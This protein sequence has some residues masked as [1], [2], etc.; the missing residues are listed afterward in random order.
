[1]KVFVCSTRYDLVLE[2]E[3]VLRVIHALGLE[4]GSMES[5]FG[6]RSCRS[7]STCLAEVRSSDLVVVVVGHRYGNVVP[8]LGVSFSHAEYLEA[9]NLGKPCLV[10]F[11]DPDV[12]IHRTHVETDPQKRELLEEWKAVLQDNHTTWRFNNEHGLAAQVVK[13]LTREV[14]GINRRQRQSREPDSHTTRLRYAIGQ[15]E[16][17]VALLLGTGDESFDWRTMRFEYSHEWVP[18]HPLI[19]SHREQWI[20]EEAV[21]ARERDITLF[22]GPCVRLHSFG[23]GVNQ[24]GDGT[25]RKTPVLSLRP[26]CWFDYVAS[27]RWLDREFAGPDGKVITL[28]PELADE[29]AILDLQPS[30]IQLSNILTVS[31]VLLTEDGWTVVGRRTGLVDNTRGV[32]QASAAEN[33]HRWKDEPSDSSNPWSLPH[34]LA[35]PGARNPRVDYD[36]APKAPPN[37][38]FTALRGLRE[39]VGREVG[40]QSTFEQVRCL[41]LAWDWLNFNPHLYMFVRISLSSI[42]VQRSIDAGRAEDRFEV[43]PE[44]MR[45]EPRGQLR[46]LLV[47]GEVADV[48][49]GVLLR[50]LVHAFGYPEVTRS[51]T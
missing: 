35:A 7:I 14:A 36:Y 10:Y 37:P 24:A 12:P 41:G 5:S 21:D 49:K 31:V 8:E 25:E 1:M 2:R 33:V 50:A 15:V 29:R 28:R 32:Y 40:N 42:E 16:A 30:R 27:N 45:F 46:D 19:D 43:T 4:P 3:A 13:D 9:L 20:A 11:K 6:A 17:K 47:D 18:L 22:N 44:L 39:E 34:Y 51:L 23:P 26:T 38:F 48:S